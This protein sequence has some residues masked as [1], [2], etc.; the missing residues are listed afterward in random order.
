MARRGMPLDFADEPGFERQNVR[1]CPDSAV[2]NELRRGVG[3]P[4]RMRPLARRD[5]HG[6]ALPDNVCE[7]VL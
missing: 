6:A 7:V 1:G 2:R 3:E 4:Q 5:H